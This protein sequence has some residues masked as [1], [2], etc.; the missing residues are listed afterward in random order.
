M[1][2]VD[3]EGDLG[4]NP[5]WTGDEYKPNKTFGFGI[6]VIKDPD[7]FAEV[8]RHYQMKRGRVLRA[9]DLDKEEQTFYSAY[10]RNSGGGFTGFYIDKTKDVPEGWNE[11]ESRENIAFVLE[12]ALDRTMPDLESEEVIVIVD[13][14]SGYTA[15][16]K[17]EPVDRVA[18]L[19]G[20]LSETHGK[21][22]QM[23]TSHTRNNP[24]VDHMQTADIIAHAL[25][26]E[27][28]LSEPAMSE[29]AGIKTIRLGK[30]TD[31]RKKR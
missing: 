30:E 24:Y 8:A 10:A 2:F 4:K 13:K 28:E 14:H 16:R 20:I 17:G 15:K 21:N 25:F 7:K 23:I 6:S 18:E 19:S 11:Q 9:K 22:V 5:R 29:E 27:V 1:V 12:E 26:R 3:E 31:I